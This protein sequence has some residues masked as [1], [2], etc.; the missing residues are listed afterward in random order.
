VPESAMTA[1]QAQQLA[2]MLLDLSPIYG[3]GESIL[4]LIT[5]KN[6]ILRVMMPIDFGRL[7]ELFQ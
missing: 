1:E 2:Q 6:S 7:L 3:T 4:Q 5:A